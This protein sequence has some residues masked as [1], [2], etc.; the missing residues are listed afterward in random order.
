[1]KKTPNTGVSAA[2]AAA[3][4]A[5]FYA[6]VSGRVQ[7]VGFRYSACREA[8]RLRLGGWVRNDDNGDVEVWAE[9]P[10]G[11]LAVFLEWLHRGPSFSRV[12]SVEKEDKSPRGYYDFNVEY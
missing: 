10:P 12:D 5:A 7:G 11:N 3:G 4:K 1:M 6:R 9:G 2:P 8:A